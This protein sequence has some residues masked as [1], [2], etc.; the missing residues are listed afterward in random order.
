MNMNKKTAAAVIK[1]LVSVT[2]G[3]LIAV[4]PQPAGALTVEGLRFLGILI[5]MVLLMVFKVFP[6]PVTVLIAL[7]ACIAFGVA[8]APT[9]FSG[10][11]STTVWMAVG[12]IGFATGII[13]SGLMKRIAYKI[14][15]WFKPTYK[16]QITSIMVAGTIL[17][18]CMPNT[19]AKVAI[20]A[21]FS[22]EMCDILGFE[23]N[24]KGAAGLFSAMFYSCNHFGF[25][26]LTGSTSAYLMM[27]LM[28]GLDFTW[29]G[30]AGATIVW[31][32]VCTVGY[33][34]FNTRYY[35]VETKELPADFTRQK[36]KEMGPMSGNE[37]FAAAVLII[38]IIAWMTTSIT[39][40]DSLVITMVLWLAMTAKG[41]FKAPEIQTRIPWTVIIMMGGINGV[42]T[43]FSSTGVSAWMQ[44]VIAPY[45]SSIVPN[46]F[47]LVIV[48]TVITYI[49]RYAVMSIMATTTIMFSVFAPLCATMGI[50]PFVV[51]WTAYVAG[52]LWSTAFNNTNYIL[53]E[54]MFQNRIGWKQAAPSNY[55]Y[56]VINLLGNLACIPVWNMLGLA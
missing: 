53:A 8:E 9:C 30:W 12:L 31:G 27:G 18:P 25:C 34:F 41:L 51:V 11:T 5:A 6:D 39:G 37:K 15:G 17:G 44:E 26:F 50:S 56:M 47:V 24:S 28:P 29:L 10:F 45:L 14:M 19:Q 48:V 32:L 33:Y 3:V 36:L 16:G 52:N 20:M 35:K 40:L 49:L 23:N 1:F 2:A 7:T 13:N 43:L 54:G 46:V 4:V 21:P 38:G 42:A 22:A 55:F